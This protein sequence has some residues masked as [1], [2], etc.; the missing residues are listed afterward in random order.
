MCNQRISK[1]PRCGY[2]RHIA[3]NLC[4]NN[5]Q[6]QLIAFRDIEKP[7][8][9]MHCEDIAQA[10]VAIWLRPRACPT[11][12]EG[13]GGIR[14]RIESER[15]DSGI[16]GVGDDNTSVASRNEGGGEG[17]GDTEDVGDGQGE[18]DTKDEGD[19]IDEADTEEERNVQGE[20]DIRSDSIIRSLPRGSTWN[21]VAVTM[22]SMSLARCRL[23]VPYNH[24]TL[25]R[26]TGPNIKYAPDFVEAGEPGM[27]HNPRRIGMSYALH[28]GPTSRHRE[29]HGLDIVRPKNWRY[30]PNPD[31]SILRP[32]DFRISTVPDETY[33][34]IMRYHNIPEVREEWAR[35]WVPGQERPVKTLADLVE[36]IFGEPQHLRPKEE[37]EV[38]EEK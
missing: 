25:Q 9:P 24:G 23:Y 17:E 31:T 34:I 28:A 33:L 5:I 4:R 14:R 22:A 20:T 12:N 19:T 36:E 26:P 1:C 8:H 27:K 11:D 21:E 35:K 18:E 7:P 3:W 29:D 13:C 15:K 10:E 32:Y 6:E 38:E 37:E 30:S 16:S 2:A